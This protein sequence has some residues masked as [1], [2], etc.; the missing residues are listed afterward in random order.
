MPQGGTRSKSG[1]TKDPT[2]RTSER[3]GYTLTALPAEGYRKRPPGLTEFIPR[4][5]ARQKAVWAE[6]WRTPQACAWSFDRWRWP[7]VATLTRLRVRSEDPDAPAA[8]FG[9]LA[10]VETRLGLS[11]EGLRF[12]GWA[13]KR[14]E[15]ATKRDEKAETAT[16][17]KRQRRLS[18]VPDAK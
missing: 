12:L 7:Q 11:E 18:S 16:R 2:S 6:L 17:P 1:P 14:D 13:I 15:L 10:K 4:P 8:I 9:E 5:T 3:A